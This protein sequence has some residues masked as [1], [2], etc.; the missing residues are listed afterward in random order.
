M[1]DAS[2][3]QARLRLEVGLLRERE[4]RRVF[5]PSVHV[6]ALAGDRVSFVLPARDAP[7]TDAALRADVLIELMAG[8]PVAGAE[9]WLCRPGV[10]SLHDDDL[11]WFAAAAL[12]C[13]V[14]GRRLLGFY[15]ITRAGWLDVGSGD[16]RMWKRLRL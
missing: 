8:Y 14:H 11:G 16:R 4:S 3:L 12:A 6:G 10:P 2:S 1:D 5:D 7:V 13:G 9:A 15:A